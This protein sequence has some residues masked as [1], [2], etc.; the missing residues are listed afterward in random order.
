[1]PLPDDATD[2]EIRYGTGHWHGYRS[3]RLMN[4]N[5]VAVCSPALLRDM[6]TQ[7]ASPP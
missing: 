1:M 6:E 4:Q 7:A 3:E 5:I 2:L